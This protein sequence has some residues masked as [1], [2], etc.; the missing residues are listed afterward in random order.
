M[1]DFL[2]SIWEVH[3]FTS[4][5]FLAGAFTMC[6]SISSTVTSLSQSAA[7]Q[8]HSLSMSLQLTPHL[9]PISILPSSS[10]PVFCSLFF[11]FSPYSFNLHL[12]ALQLHLLTLTPSFLP[13]LHLLSLSLQEHISI[14]WRYCC[15]L[16]R[17]VMILI[18]CNFLFPSTPLSNCVDESTVA[19]KLAKEGYRASVWF[20]CFGL[21]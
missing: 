15:L 20:V 3:N 9:L 8:L 11:S 14:F 19:M 4:F 13:L 16:F 6:V 5:A 21:Q 2:L 10:T 7:L 12:P 17:V 1:Q 18:A